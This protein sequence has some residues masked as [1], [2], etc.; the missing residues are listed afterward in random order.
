[1]I[2]NVVQFGNVLCMSLR[3]VA[4]Y[5]FQPTFHAGPVQCCIAI[6]KSN[7]MPIVWLP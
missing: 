6:V 1:M 7:T 2:D 5:V 4:N 3:V